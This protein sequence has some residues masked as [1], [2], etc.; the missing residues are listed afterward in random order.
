[1]VQVRRTPTERGLRILT[2]TAG[3]RRTPMA[4][5]QPTPTPTEARRRVKLGMV[6]N[7]PLPTAPPHIILLRLIMDTTRLLPIMVTIHPPPWPFTEQDAITVAVA[8]R[9]QAPQL[10]AL[11]LALLWPHPS[12]VPRASSA[13]AAGY[14]AGAANTSTANA[15]AAAANANAA[16]ANANAAAANANMAAANASYAMGS[17]QAV[18]PAGCIT[19]NVSG[20]GTYYLCGNTWFQPSY[21]ANG[22]YYRVVPAP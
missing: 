15:N 11:L 7:T 14:T 4:G 18:L 17:V 20:G 6:R 9:W 22:V 13:Y 10:Q 5:A 16:A 3:V 1:M 8:G 2:T 19:P 21:G 12:L